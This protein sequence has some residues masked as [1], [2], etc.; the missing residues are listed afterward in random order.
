MPLTKPSEIFQRKI[1]AAHEEYL[2]TP[3]SERKANGLA[4]ALN[5]QAEWTFRYYE[6]RADSNRLLGATSPMEFREKLFGTCPE[7][8]MMW[9]LADA[10]KHRQLD[11]PA[12]SVTASTAAYVVQGDDLVVAAPYYQSF[13]KAAA[14]AAEL[15]K[16][17]PD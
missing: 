13:S 2:Q 6:G 12:H 16:G 4:T 5:D 17:W 15:W 8:R 10:D 7:L 1:A 11:N 14:T 9:D 3:I